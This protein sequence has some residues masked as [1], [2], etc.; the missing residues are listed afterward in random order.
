MTFNEFLEAVGLSESEFLNALKMCAASSRSGSKI[1]PKRDCCDIFTNNY[2]ANILKIHQANVDI[3]FIPYEYACVAYIL[4]YLTKNESG[5]SRLLH[6]IEVE[7]A[8]YG[9]TP[10]DKM[11]LFSRALANSREVSRPEVV[12]R[13]LGLHFCETTRTHAFIQAAHPRN[14]DGLLWS[15]LHDLDDDESP[16]YNNIIDYYVKRPDDLED[17]HPNAENSNTALPFYLYISGRAGTSK[18]F[19]LRTLIEVFSSNA[20]CAYEY[21]QVKA[22]FIDEVSMVGSNKL[23]QIHLRREQI[24]GKRE[25]PFS[26][27]PVICTG[28]FLQLPPVQDS[29]I[30]GNT[31]RPNCCDTTAPNKW[32]L[33]FKMFQL[34]QKM[35]S[36]DDPNFSALCDRIGVNSLEEE[37][38]S[39]LK[40]RITQCP[41]EESNDSFKEG[42]LAIIVRDNAKREEINDTKLLL[43]E[44]NSTIFEVKDVC[45]NADRYN[46]AAVMNLPYTRT[47]SL[48]DRLEVKVDAPVMLT[49]NT[50]KSDGL[51]N[52]S[53]GY[54]VDMD[55]EREI[56]WV[57][58][59]GTT[60]S[61]ASVIG[62]RKYDV[63]P[64]R[65]SIRIQRS[66]FPLVLAYAI[67]AHKS[68]GQTLEE[69][70][71]D[72]S[73]K[74][75]SAPG[76]FY[77]AVTRVKKLSN[78]F[79]RS[80]DRSMIKTISTWQ[81][82]APQHAYENKEKPSP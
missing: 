61:K 54:V 7:S 32:K 33:H 17:L 23:H 3:S 10:Q 47:D 41:N 66:Q 78:L 76:S 62:R 22:I 79:L 74:G 5:L 18:T 1:F 63:N 58:F 57:K 49:V 55:E 67:T 11:K 35:R 12:Y 77:V 53:R 2:N 36:L 29:W 48:P 51:T 24:F 14:R 72:F 39:T 50:D 59:S 38:K 70:I 34:T 13:M 37:H 73:G 80:F 28:D 8:K 15:D 4:G 27:L 43:I 68:Q 30:F 69:V 46:K 56:V 9:R 20:T 65:N 25:K 16:F 21:S 42:K 19:L 60:G 26:T 52:G 64:A 31:S 45:R 81:D 71:I 40:D 75:R 44:N 82:T 6:Q